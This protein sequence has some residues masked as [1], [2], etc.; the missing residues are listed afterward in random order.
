MELEG[1]GIA[2]QVEALCDIGA[3]DEVLVSYL[4]HGLDYVERQRRLRPYGFCCQCPQCEE[5]RSAR[6]LP[7][8]AQPLVT[9]EHD[10]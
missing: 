5:E 1:A 7:P 10:F 9:F 3:G 4:G 6:G 2:L 8:P